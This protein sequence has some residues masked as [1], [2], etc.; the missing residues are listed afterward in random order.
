M[1]EG[2]RRQAGRTPAESE[3]SGEGEPRINTQY[4]RPNRDYKPAGGKDFWNGFGPAAWFT[5]NERSVVSHN[6]SI[7]SWRGWHGQAC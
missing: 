4:S 6:W 2:A 7:M 3:A 1:T 5:R